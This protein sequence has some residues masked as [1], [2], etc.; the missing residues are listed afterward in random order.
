MAEKDHKPDAVGTLH[1]R[2][3]KKRKKLTKGKQNRGN[4]L[5]QLISA[6][7]NNSKF[8]VEKQV[9]GPEISKNHL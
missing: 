9:Y 3:E 5:G 2:L 6:K 4:A 1:Q 7:A 8:K